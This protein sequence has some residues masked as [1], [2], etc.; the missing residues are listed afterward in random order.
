MKCRNE[1]HIH[2]VLSKN[3]LIRTVGILLFLAG[4]FAFLLTDYQPWLGSVPAPPP[5]MPAWSGLSTSTPQW[6]GTVT[7][8]VQSWEWRDGQAVYHM[9]VA[10][11]S[12]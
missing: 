10:P 3:V 11:V 7:S 9:D 5:A 6:E 4:S 12:S 2:L 8:A 1:D